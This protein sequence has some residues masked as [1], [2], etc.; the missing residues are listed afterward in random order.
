MIVNMLKHCLDVSRPVDKVAEEE[1]S[2]TQLQLTIIGVSAI[3]IA[4]KIAVTLAVILRW[5]RVTKCT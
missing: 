4:Y 1:G 5:Q 2:V 3:A